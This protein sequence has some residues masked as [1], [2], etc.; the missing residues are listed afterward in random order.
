MLIFSL[1]LGFILVIQIPDY[2]LVGIEERNEH[3]DL[4]CESAGG[5]PPL[6]AH[7]EGVC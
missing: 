7:I 3:D 1:I 2:G 6:L 4:S 5:N